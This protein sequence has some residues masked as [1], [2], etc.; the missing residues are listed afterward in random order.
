[1]KGIA[2]CT[3]S[4]YSLQTLHDACLHEYPTQMY[5]DA[6]QVQVPQYGP[7]SHRFLF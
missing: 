7:R 1:M 6:L 3:A 4:S 5:N 2:F